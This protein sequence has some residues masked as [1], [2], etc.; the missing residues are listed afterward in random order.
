MRGIQTTVKIHVRSGGRK[1]DETMRDLKT[2]SLVY[3]LPGDGE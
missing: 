1:K 3:L 2:I